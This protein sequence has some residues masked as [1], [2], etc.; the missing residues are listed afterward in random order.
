MGI[1][2][3]DH[4]SKRQSAFSGS[5]AI[6]AHR[7]VARA[8]RLRAGRG[9]SCALPASEAKGTC[10]S[11]GLRRV[12]RFCVLHVVPRLL[13]SSL[14]TPLFCLRPR[15]AGTIVRQAVSVK[16]RPLRPCHASKRTRRLKN[17]FA[18]CRS[19]AGY[20]LRSAILP[21]LDLRPGTRTGLD[22]PQ[23]PGQHRKTV[24]E[25]RKG[26]APPPQIASR[27]EMASRC[28]AGGRLG[29]GTAS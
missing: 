19:I 21:F 20:P 13:D 12:C 2:R 23:F 24:R 11:G 9:V 3:A 4:G 18:P 26:P 28:A 25:G 29:T 10:K 1:V 15:M 22:G 8:C 27:A 17:E 6:R 16:R 5:V 7:A 14:I